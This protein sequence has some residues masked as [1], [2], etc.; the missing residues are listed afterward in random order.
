MGLTT[1]CLLIPVIAA[2]ILGQRCS[3]RPRE[4]QSGAAFCWRIPCLCRWQAHNCRTLS[5]Q[6][7]SAHHV[8][9]TLQSAAA[10]ACVRTHLGL[11]ALCQRV[12]W[13]DGCDIPGRPLALVQQPIA[14]R[15]TA[16]WDCI[17]S[18]HVRQLQ[19]R[20]TSSKAHTSEGRWLVCWDHPHP[21]QTCVSRA[22][23]QYKHTGSCWRAYWRAT[24]EEG[25]PLHCC[26]VLSCCWLQHSQGS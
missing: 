24:V 10:A 14:A 11:C 15:P 3:R 13:T 1:I 22:R 6:V 26:R 2:R 8:S 5:A 16:T 17:V 21:A 7:V 12:A 20:A 23:Q 18:A 19:V 25:L 4:V 9:C